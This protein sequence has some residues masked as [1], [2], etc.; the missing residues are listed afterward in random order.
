M[1]SEKVERL[2]S[3]ALTILAKDK[4]FNF[5][6]QFDIKVRNELTFKLKMKIMKNLEA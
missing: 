5:F 6:N 2:A 3:T 1:L 4:G